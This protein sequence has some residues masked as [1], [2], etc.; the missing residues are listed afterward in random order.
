MRVGIIGLQ[1]E[2][3]TFIA[4]PTTLEHFQGDWWARGQQVRESHGNAPHEIGGFFQ[5]L[6][7]AGIEAVPL[8]AA[9]AMP[10]AAITADAGDALVRIML[11]ELANAG[12][13]DGLLVAP[14][15]AAV[16]EA[17]RDFDGY[18]LSR[19]RETIGTKPMICT[20]DPHVNLSQRMI[21]SCDATI[22]YRT[23]PHI[24]QHARGL[25]AAA[26]MARTLR[27]EIKPVQACA[28]PPMAINIEKQYTD[29]PPC[30][31]MYDL[32]DDIR[33]RAGVLSVSIALGFPYADVEEMGSACN[34]VTDGDAALA[35]RYADELAAYM[36]EHRLD[37]D[38]AFLDVDDALD[39]AAKLPGT[40]CLLDMGDNIGGG[41]AADGTTI[42]HA[43]QR[44]GGPRTFIP[45]YDPQ[46]QRQARDAGVGARVDLVIGGKTDDQHGKPLRAS[47][48]VRGLYDG[49]FVEPQVRHGGRTGFDMGPTT[50]VETD[51]GLTVQLTSVA[52]YPF[53]LVQLTCCDVVPRKFDVVV[54]KGVNAPCA[55]YAEACDHFI[56]VNTPG[57]TCADMTQFTY[58]HRRKPL[59]PFEA[60]E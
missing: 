39:R 7:D 21:D 17:H 2:S 1:H 31:P 38:G 15:G 35:Q 58:H 33:G 51:A 12:D 10:T 22:I 5:G 47:C 11:E 3:N 6:D 27:G 49:K 52:T 53:S 50:I 60:I 36:L 28:L 18:W 4:R 23:N 19:L 54:A 48:I 34:V 45:I 37:F 57:S 16:C 24:D 41:S 42:A 40:V 20:L 29:D 13:L 43:V 46:S 25:E 26:L 44:R 9:V 14:H 59:H 30:K 55:A 8:F 56:R 32:A